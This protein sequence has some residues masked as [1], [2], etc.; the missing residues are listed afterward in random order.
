MLGPGYEDA[1]LGERTPPRSRVIPSDSRGPRRGG[2]PGQSE[3]L[4][5][6]D[7]QGSGWSLKAERS[8]IFVITSRELY[9]SLAYSMP[10]GDAC[11]KRK[12]QQRQGTRPWDSDHT[13]PAKLPF[14][15]CMHSRHG[16]V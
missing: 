12:P 15:F 9:R 6:L 5:C 7:G 10:S 8:A 13:L 2:D 16:V 14:S 3:P 11:T 1:D 4:G